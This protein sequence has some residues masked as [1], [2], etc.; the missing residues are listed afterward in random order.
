MNQSSIWHK[1]W[2]VSGVTSKVPTMVPAR[3][4]VSQHISA[5]CNIV[6]SRLI[7]YFLPRRTADPLS[8]E[9][10]GEWIS[11]SSFPEML[12]KSVN[13]PRRLDQPIVSSVSDKFAVRH[14]LMWSG[15]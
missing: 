14:T 8:Q 15:T 3:P 7:C 13:P 11:R 12:Q 1:G 2:Q 9:F 10:E 5:V 6:R 4:A